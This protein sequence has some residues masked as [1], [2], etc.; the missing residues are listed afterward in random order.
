MF[1][2]YVIHILPHRRM[3]FYFRCQMSEIISSNDYLYKETTKYRYTVE[4]R[5]SGYLLSGFPF[6]RAVEKS[7]VTFARNC[8]PISA[9]LVLDTP[10]FIDLCVID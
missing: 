5:L 6:I 10:E 1:K 7:Q 9:R 8:F 2:M 4:R 3:R